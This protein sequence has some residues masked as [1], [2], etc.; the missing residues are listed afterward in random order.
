MKISEKKKLAETRL[1]LAE[2]AAP[3]YFDGTGKTALY[4]IKSC[5]ILEIFFDHHQELFKWQDWWG[6]SP[7]GYMMIYQPEMIN[8]IFKQKFENSFLLSQWI[9]TSESQ[10]K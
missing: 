10:Y 2:G 8:S 9:I 4:F 6:R 3:I 1:L 5:D 7:I